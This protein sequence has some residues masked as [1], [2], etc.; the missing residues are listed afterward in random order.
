MSRPEPPGPRYGRYVGLLGV[1]ILILITVNTALTKPNGATGIEPGRPLP[2]FAAPLLQGGLVGDVNIATH[3]DQGA[4]GKVPACSV[5]GAG[6]LNICELYE[7]N[8]VVLVLFVDAGSCTGILS[9]MQSLLPAFPSVRFAAIA[10]KGDRTQLRRLVRAHGLSMPIGIDKDGVLAALYKVASCPQ[11]S[12]VY[13]G[14]VVQ[15]RA[16]LRRPSLATLRARVAELV[17]ATAARARTGTGG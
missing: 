3:A 10:I 7:H 15:S 16:L 9:D 17:A 14:G 1:L 5:R 13:P 11:V 8:P 6:V 12:F 2:P 4:A